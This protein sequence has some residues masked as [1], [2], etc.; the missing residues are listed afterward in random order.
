MIK[1]NQKGFTLIELIIVIVIIGIL[2]AIAIPKYVDMSSAARKAA[3]DGVTGALKAAAAI[4]YADRVVNS[5]AT[6]VM[7]ATTIVSTTYMSDTGGAV[8]TATNVLTATISGVS[9]TWS[10]TAPAQVSGHTPTT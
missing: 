7:D 6:N 1:S 8:A 4:A 10:Y 3:A 2:A 5:S 9:Y